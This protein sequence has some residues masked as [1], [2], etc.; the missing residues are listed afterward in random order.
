MEWYNMSL[1]E[2]STINN[3]Q[4]FS[5]IL[6]NI[7]SLDKRILGKVEMAKIYLKQL[8]NILN[9]NFSDLDLYITFEMVYEEYEKFRNLNTSHLFF[10]NHL[11]ILYPKIK[12]YKTTSPIICNFSGEVI[13]T[14][15]EYIYYRPLIEDITSHKIYVVTPTIKCSTYC[16]EYLPKNISELE[17]FHRK[18]LSS[19]NDMNAEINYYD[20][21]CNMKTDGFRLQLIRKP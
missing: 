14:N 3:K 10:Y 20:V 7:N 18:L 12:I 21:S 15:S 2:L 16:E 11:A 6:E 13:N 4:I 9:N 17:E 19:Y 5:E 8:D 1:K